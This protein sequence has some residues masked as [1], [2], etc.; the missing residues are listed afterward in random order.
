MPMIPLEQIHADPNNARRTAAGADADA[1]LDAGIRAHGVLQPILVRPWPVSTD[2]ERPVGY[3]IVYG[4]RRFAS[5]QRIGLAEIKAEITDEQDEARLAMIQLME[6]EQRAEMS[7]LDTWAAVERAAAAGLSDATIRV[8]L[9]IASEKAVRQMRAMGR[10]HSDIQARIRETGDLPMSHHLNIICQAPVEQQGAAFKAAKREKGA[11][12][13]ARL[14]EG[15]RR[16]RIPFSVAR[17]DRGLYQGAPAEDLFGNDEELADDA[18]Q[19]LRLQREWAEQEV[20]R[21]L[22]AGFGRAELVEMDGAGFMPAPDGLYGYQSMSIDAAPKK[23]S[24]RAGLLYHIAVAWNGEIKERV[25]PLPVVQHDAEPEA[26]DDEAGQDGAAASTPAAPAALAKKPQAA[27]TKD[28]EAAVIQAKRRAAADALALQSDPWSLLA[29]AMLLLEDRSTSRETSAL[30]TRDGRLDLDHPERDRAT[31][32]VA[33]RVMSECLTRDSHPMRTVERIGAAVQGIAV[34]PRTA[35]ALK[36]L[37]RP[38]LDRVRQALGIEVKGPLAAARQQIEATGRDWITGE[39]LS[40]LGW[41][42]EP[43][44]SYEPSIEDEPASTEE[45][46]H[47]PAEA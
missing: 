30:L 43:I 3:R 34:L 13:W 36:V 28:G 19:F 40:E 27:L 6:N 45:A 5:A 33:H 46:E 11:T 8:T 35:E 37:N 24:E 4:H 1:D 41:S 10:L 15:C 9:N 22:R 29:I 18:P 14:A 26:R 21:K 23:K 47:E 25:W 20:A 42:V 32:E 39:Q 38:A 44:Y 16:V 17:F 2:D 12:F 31:L 7:A